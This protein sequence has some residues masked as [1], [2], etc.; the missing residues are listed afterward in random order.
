MFEVSRFEKVFTFQNV[1]LHETIQTFTE[2]N[3]AS[4]T[5]TDH[6]RLL[7]GAVA[8]KEDLIAMRYILR[9]VLYE[10]MIPEEARQ[11]VKDSHACFTLLCWDILHKN[12]YN[13][14]HPLARIARK[15]VEDYQ[16]HF[17]RISIIENCVDQLSDDLFGLIPINALG[18]FEL[19]EAFRGLGVVINNQVFFPCAKR[20]ANF[21]FLTNTEG[22][23][24][25][26]ILIQK[27]NNVSAVLIM[28][29]N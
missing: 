1:L 13:Y 7:I 15:F 23:P 10:G 26:S 12:E 25:G 17:T 24:T 4:E 9:F 28:D 3:G 2:P 11:Y 6:L 8:T 20:T 18:K 21:T 27:N 16:Q 14:E 19:E 22:K 5:M 29:F